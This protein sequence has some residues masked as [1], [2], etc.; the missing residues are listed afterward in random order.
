MINIEKS[1]NALREA[2]KYL[3]QHISDPKY[4]NDPISQTLEIM[5]WDIKRKISELQENWRGF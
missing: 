4:Y 1:I 3:D 2:E 5:S